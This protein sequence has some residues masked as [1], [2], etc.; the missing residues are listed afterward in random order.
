MK[1]I[2]Y[3]LLGLL[4]VMTF[5]PSAAQHQLDSV[6]M[7]VKLQDDGSARVTEKRVARRVHRKK[8]DEQ[9]S[10]NDAPFV[11]A[12]QQ[13][14]VGGGQGRSFHQCRFVGKDSCF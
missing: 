13:V 11:K 3:L 4:C 1:K 9:H 2:R 7:L 6:F 12:F 8:D 14:E 5:L 10:P